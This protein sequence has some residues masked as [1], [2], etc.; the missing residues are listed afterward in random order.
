MLER[1]GQTLYSVRRSRRV[2]RSAWQSLPLSV[3]HLHTAALQ[4][5]P[6]VIEQAEVHQFLFQLAGRG[7][8]ERVGHFVQEEIGKLLPSPMQGLSNSRGEATNAIYGFANDMIRGGSP[9]PLLMSG[10]SRTADIERV[11]TVGVHGPRALSVVIVG[12]A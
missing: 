12:G 3:S 1:V 8:P 10:P 2:P 11:L 5:R 7:V 6:A 4:G 9:H